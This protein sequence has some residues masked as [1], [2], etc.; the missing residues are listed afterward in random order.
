MVT[1]LETH[2]RAVVPRIV[3]EK[4]VRC[5]L[6]WPGEPITEILVNDINQMK[7]TF[8]PE[9]FSEVMRQYNLTVWPAQIV[10]YV[11]AAI[12]LYL[13]FRPGRSSDK[14]IA[15]VLA[16]FWFWMG[17]AYHWAFFAAINPAGKL[18]GAVFVLQGLFFVFEGVIRDKIVFAHSNDWRSNTG[19]VMAIF[20]P[21]IYPILGYFLGHTFPVSPTFG[22][23]CPTTIFTFGLLLMTRR[24]P[25][26]VA[27]IPFLW[28]L[29]GY[30]AALLLGVKE[31]I[32]LIIAGVIGIVVVMLKRTTAIQPNRPAPVGVK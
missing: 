29:L 32:A 12:A 19:L 18:F 16:L 20:G 17:I 4:A 8:T 30:P 7:L 24:L 26:Y 10:V 3:A 28:S 21:V 9:Q 2:N 13:V 25:K 23:P 14:V 11:L 22:L 31:D 15:S 6:N 5:I 27:L 1:N